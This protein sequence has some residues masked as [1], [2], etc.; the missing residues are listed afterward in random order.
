MKLDRIITISVA[1][2]LAMAFL[3]IQALA[4][5]DWVC[6]GCGKQVSELEGDICPY[7][8]YVR[9]AHD[10]APATCV[11]PKTC[12]VCGE[13][14]GSPDPANH[15]GE[16]EI[17]NDRAATCQNT[18]YTGDI[19]CASCGRVLEK[20]QGIPARG[21]QWDAGHTII[22]ATCTKPGL[23]RYTCTDCG[24]EKDEAVPVDPN[25][26]AVV[27]YRGMKRATCTEAGYTGDT[28]CAACGKTITVGSILF[29][30]GHDWQPAT[31][32]APKTCR[33]CGKTEGE[34]LPSFN[35]EDMIV[36]NIVCFG[37]YP[38]TADGT[39]KT[40]IEWQVLEVDAENSKAL[41]ISRYGLD[42]KPYNEALTGVSWATCTLR[43]W[44]NQ[45][46]LETAFM[47]TEQDIILM[48]VVDN[49]RSQG[50]W[51]TDGG[52]NTEDRIFLLSYAEASRY[53]RVARE[54]E[55]NITSRVS[56]T[57]YAK[58]QG[59][60]SSYSNRTAD[61]EEAGVWWLRSPGNNRVSA[62]C[63]IATGAL[64]DANV[65]DLTVSV[66]P[67]LWVDFGP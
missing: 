29:A 4:A 26:H 37:T 51:S 36:G 33:L 39:D 47:K 11:S 67:A 41:L 44:L 18:G 28:Y 31:K 10:W 2:L 25:H 63:V 8:G 40:P 43:R 13:T 55:N 21:H 19:C 42:A 30:T 56:A 3:T 23:A 53:F 34:P 5:D 60:N 52:K 7:C 15:T 1:L 48:T 12:R 46:F 66:R 16:T 14:E 50:Y 65:S 59:V 54:Y 61:R 9:H 27:M 22:P 49:G 20:G 62:S 57:A 6:A 24:A 17:R 35:M 38:Q 45:A 32:Q 64:R 58:A